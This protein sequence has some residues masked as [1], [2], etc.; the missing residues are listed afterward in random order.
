MLLDITNNILAS[1]ILK[2]N[3]STKLAMV[4]LKKNVIRARYYLG[5]KILQAHPLKTDKE[6]KAFLKEWE[7]YSTSQT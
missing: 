5:M 7:T 3:K 4:N 2:N 6:M 1:T